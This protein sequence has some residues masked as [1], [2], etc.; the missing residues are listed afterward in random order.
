MPDDQE[1]VLRCTSQ[2]FCLDVL[3]HP[4]HHDV[5]LISRSGAKF[6][7]NKSALA[8]SSKFFKSIF[9]EIAFNSPLALEETLCVITNFEDEELELFMQFCKQGLLPTCDNVGE[10]NTDQSTDQDANELIFKSFG[11]D[12]GRIRSAEGKDSSDVSQTD[13]ATGFQLVH[14]PN[15]LA[16]HISQE[17][18]RRRKRKNESP[19]YPD[20]GAMKK[21]AK[22]V[23]VEDPW[24]QSEDG[25]GFNDEDETSY[26][27]KFVDE[28]EEDEIKE[29][30]EDQDYVYVETKLED[31]SD[32]EENY[33]SSND[34][35]YESPVVRR[36]A[37]KSRNNK[38]KEKAKPVST[39]AKAARRK[40][41]NQ[42]GALFEFP[43][44]G[45]RDLD[46]PF[47]CQRCIS[48][49]ESLSSY[50]Q[51]F[52]RHD[53]ELPPKN[54]S[55]SCLKCFEFTSNSGKDV[56]VHSRTCS[57]HFEDDGKRF[58]YYCVF[59]KDVFQS[60]QDF[61]DHLPKMHPGKEELIFK[62]Y[63]C[64]A[65]GK[66][67]NTATALNNHLRMEGPFHVGECGHC[68]LKVS[69]WREHQDHLKEFH[70][71]KMLHVC[72][73]CGEKKFEQVEDL[74]GHRR[75][76]QRIHSLSVIADG[77]QIIK[78][79]ND[80]T[81]CMLCNTQLQSTAHKIRKHLVEYHPEVLIECKICKHK[82]VSQKAVACHMKHMHSTKQYQCDL[83]GKEYVHESQLKTHYLQNH[84]EEKHRPI[85]CADCGKGF[86]YKQQYLQHVE[87]DHKGIKKE[88]KRVICDI[89]GKEMTES[90]MKSHMEKMHGMGDGQW[91]CQICNCNCVTEGRYKAHMKDK[92]TEAPCEECG[93]MLKV[94]KLRSH[95]IQ[96]HTPEH[97]KP[98]VCYTCDPPKGFISRI[99]LQDHKNVHTGEKPWACDFCSYTCSNYSNKIKH[100]KASH[101]EQLEQS[102][103]NART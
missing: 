66:A 68:K 57:S 71:G 62:K 44:E 41:K 16:S 13:N 70:D 33:A 48:G 72:G 69:S 76:C 17:T 1:L 79:D 61:F 4:D 5:A 65:C 80:A 43:Q 52:L 19:L 100:M 21:V 102:R 40:K 18:R 26:L 96:R 38:P 39:A 20:F 23:V 25:G 8:A 30:T 63:T 55:W 50:R 74:K 88:A 2:I 87:R 3:N 77:K 24:L 7:I 89:C 92:H 34:A 10:S 98:Y 59:C 95:K 22:D 58:T 75:I 97:L 67:N 51:H 73:Y 9:T 49:F 53:I 86:V 29:E 37:R 85:Q 12:V 99:K 15:K 91:I 42:Y 93:M 83:C 64:S 82:M 27:T 35:D 46:K 36:K 11:V 94:S 28:N 60:Y 32:E 56:L 31:E 81:V 101:R 54:N 47:Q 84:A 6:G 78:S 103:A 45:S 14:Q 90:N